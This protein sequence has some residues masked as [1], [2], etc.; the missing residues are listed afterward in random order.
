MDYNKIL[1]NLT[2][3]NWKSN[4]IDRCAMFAR[5]TNNGWL[6]EDLAF[7]SRFSWFKQRPLGRS[8]RHISHDLVGLLKAT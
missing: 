8:T 3:Y 6:L 4:L 5:E 1:T 7:V 2:L